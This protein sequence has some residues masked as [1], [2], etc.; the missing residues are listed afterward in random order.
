MFIRLPVRRARFF[1]SGREEEDKQKN[2]NAGM[3]MHFTG[4]AD[5]RWIYDVECFAL[6]LIKARIRFRGF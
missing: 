1:V 6:T 4:Y 2:K 5:E 3:M